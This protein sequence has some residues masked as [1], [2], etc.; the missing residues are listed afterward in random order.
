MTP[1]A[2]FINAPLDEAHP[3]PAEVVCLQAVVVSSGDHYVIRL[4]EREV[5]AIAGAILPQL[6][7]G[8]VVVAYQARD[9]DIVSIAALLQPAAGT[10][11][12]DRPIT[13]RSGQTICLDVGSA[14]V[15][16]T[17]EGLIRSVALKIEQDARDLVD[18]DAAEVRIN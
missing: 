1:P 12:E 3:Q 13:L 9:S 8:D 17:A 4:G 11:L 15:R 10:R 2:L 6:M 5:P 7:T 18:I 16:L 14:V